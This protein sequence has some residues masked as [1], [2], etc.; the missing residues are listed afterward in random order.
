MTA[1]PSQ[2]YALVSNKLDPLGVT[3]V[4]GGVNVALFADH[5][6][7]VDFCI[8]NADGSET[9][10]R[11][12]DKARGIWHGFV[13]GVE[14]GARYGFRVHGEWNP[15]EGHRH[16]PNKFLIDPY[17]KAIDGNWVLHEAVFGYKQ[18][19]TKPANESIIDTRDSAPF[20]PCGIVVK[21]DFDWTGDVKPDTRWHKTVIYEA[22]VKGMTMQHPDVPEHL[23]GTYAGLAHE[24][25]INHLHSI[26]VT[27]IELLPIHQIGHE[28][29]L[30]RMGMTNYWGYNT[31]GFFA[32]HHAYSSSGHRGEQINEFKQMVKTFHQNGIEVLLDVVYNHTC[33]G[34]PMG[35]MMSFK[36]IDNASYYRLVDEDPQHY[37]DTT[38]CSNTLN[39]YHPQVMQLVLDSLRY[40][41]SEMHVDGFRFDLA[42]SLARINHD[43]DLNGPLMQAIAQ[44]P[45]LRNVKLISEPW[46]LG[47]GGYQVG[48]YPRIW[49]EWNDR[50][51][52]TARDYWRGLAPGVSE[53]ASRM[54]GSSDLFV[55]EDRRPRASINFITAHDGFTLRDLVSYNQKHNEA[56]REGNRDGNDHNRSWNH[57]VEGETT[58]AAINQL[59]LQQQR[60]MM[61]MLTLASGVPM[62]TA[63]DEHGRTQGGNNNA[64]CQDTPISWVDWNI[65]GDRA[66]LLST[67]QNLMHLRKEHPAFHHRNYR[68]GSPTIIGG[69]KDMAWFAKSGHELTADEWLDTEL[70]TLG[71]FINQSTQNGDESSTCSFL[72]IMHSG[73]E[74][75]EFTLPDSAWASEW[76]I[77]I[78]TTLP[79]A[80]SPDLKMQPGQTLRLFARSAL[81][82]RASHA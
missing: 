10:W 48:N 44:D 57:G 40:W 80:K 82:L 35:P 51:R 56:N 67:V 53:L 23:R 42:P 16:N 20:M 71:M 9:R 5:A 7:A 33:E 54:S 61:L 32:P 66:D 74:S 68:W 41:V 22:H 49:S 81:V 15:K 69:P 38:G 34:G 78:D 31:L 63:G 50:F 24:S 58:D 55:D 52:D 70:K 21:D 46:D 27:A 6:S 13:P 18:D 25:I 28:E 29:H 30:V 72:V 45:V 62:F 36:G 4:D 60:N 47:E 76:H 37:F 3:L 11:L 75:V 26:G 73:S 14:A 79:G 19:V 2:N 8:R 43:V 12:P 77:E 1:L 39:T 17:A 64:Y 65:E 59:R